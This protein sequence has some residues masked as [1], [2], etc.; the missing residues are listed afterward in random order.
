MNDLKCFYGI[1]WLYVIFGLV[2]LF[3][4][5]V[6]FFVYMV[7]IIRSESVGFC[8]KYYESFFFLKE[9]EYKVGFNKFWLVVNMFVF[10]S[11]RFWGL[12]YR[13]VM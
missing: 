13:V 11:F 4:L 3:F 10:F 9:I 2:I 8:L 7:Y 1:Y 6:L 5:F 12:Y